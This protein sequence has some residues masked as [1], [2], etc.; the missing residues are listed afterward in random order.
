MSTAFHSAGSDSEEV[1]EKQVTSLLG[2]SSRV[3]SPS[4]YGS[5][6]DSDE[7]RA[8][9]LRQYTSLAQRETPATCAI[10]CTIFSIIGAVL[11]VGFPSFYGSIITARCHVCTLFYDFLPSEHFLTPMLVNAKIGLFALTDKPPSSF[12]NFPL[13]SVPW[14]MN[15]LQSL[16]GG[17]PQAPVAATMKR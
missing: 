12:P 9:R 5:G 10:C 11:L 16:L 7:R 1:M 3:R 6:S 15:L 4:G 13:R 17:Y 2:S 14:T 8:S